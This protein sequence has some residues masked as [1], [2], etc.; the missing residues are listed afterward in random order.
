MTP[1]A[2]LRAAATR[3]REHATEA[4]LALIGPAL[5]DWLDDAATD[6]EMIGH[7]PH[8]LAV[9]RAILGSPVDRS[10]R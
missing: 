7:N 1:A 2:E 6:A 9:A 3:L 5:A 4:Y 8:A 10:S